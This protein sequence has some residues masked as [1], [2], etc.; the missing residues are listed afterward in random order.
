VR[1]WFPLAILL[2][3]AWLL[4]VSI[5]IS[6]SGG[7]GAGQTTPL[8]GDATALLRQSQEAMLELDSLQFQMTTQWEGREDTYRVAWQS[9]DAFHV[10]APYVV[11][12]M[13]SGQE[14]Q[15][16]DYGFV[17]A[18]A[19]GER[20]YTRQCVEEGADCEPWGE[21]LRDGTYVPMGAIE[22]D[23][24][25]T[26]ELLGLASDAQVVGQEEVDGVQ[27]THI[28]GKA[29]ITQA[30]VQSWRRAEET[31]GPLYWGEECMM[32]DSDAGPSEE[33]H[34]TTL[35]EHV[36]MAEESARVQGQT[37]ATVEVWVGQDD[38]LMRR[39]EFP[40][41]PGVEPTFGLFTYSRFNEVTV[42]P[43]K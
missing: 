27:C 2:S 35:E 23:P 15:V 33:C 24:M 34:A 19:I 41:L 9:P 38:R 11:A 22:L 13:E 39:L 42:E 43:P 25:W 8:T 7:N 4:L 29:N 6:R 32:I 40:V 28:R 37:Q 18:I 21:G 20:M 36:A 26:I 30:M 16:T 5:L 14:T 1:I 10:L 31:R 17:E 3:V 12:H